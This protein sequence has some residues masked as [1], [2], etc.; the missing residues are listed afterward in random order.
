MRLAP[1]L[2]LLATLFLARPV[3]GQEKSS[4]PLA[5][6]LALAA[7]TEAATPEATAAEARSLAERWQA[8]EE[9]VL[10]SGTTIPVRHDALV[11]ALRADPRDGEAIAARMVELQAVTARWADPAY[12]EDT[13]S[14]ARERL[15]NILAGPA[16]QWEEEQPGFWQQLWQRILRFLFDLIPFG[17]GAIDLANIVLAV[18][19]GA[20]LFAALALAARSLLRSFRPEAAAAGP[21]G[22]DNGLTAAQALQQADAHSQQGDYR[23]AVRYLYLS[24]LL[25]LEEHGLLRYDRSRTNREYLRGVAGE[26]ELYSMLQSVVDVFDRV[27]YGFQTLD[28]A[29]YERY[30][31]Q[32]RDLQARRAS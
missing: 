9:V 7:E 30:Q 11:A 3:A 22:A 5:D 4:L 28:E 17:S 10:P 19:G 18:L 13:A 20:V 12:D 14:A 29:T 6:Y 1:F 23:S 24:T 16:F 31:S 27:W 2:L 21:D 15:D 26:P 8:L 25:L 32:V